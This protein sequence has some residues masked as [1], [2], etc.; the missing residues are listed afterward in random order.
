MIRFKGCRYPKEVILQTVRWYLAYTLSTR[1]LEEMLKKRGIS[2][3]HST[4][5]DWVLKFSP[6]LAK[7]FQKRSANQVI[8]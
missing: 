5:N 1:N 4:I 2:V 3:D 7:A 6:M 8:G